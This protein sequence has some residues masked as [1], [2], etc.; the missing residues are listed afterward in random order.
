MNRSAP[1]IRKAILALAVVVVLSALCIAI[2]RTYWN[3]PT[4]A[5]SWV[6]IVVPAAL[7]AA[8]MAIL[9]RLATARLLL[10]QWLPVCV[11]RARSRIG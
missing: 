3:S 11:V 10:H 4:G 8:L 2:F 1:H 7:G 6:A 9:N 5:A